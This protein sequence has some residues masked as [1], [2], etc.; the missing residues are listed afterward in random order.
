MILTGILRPGSDGDR[1]W[2]GVVEFDDEFGISTSY[3][4][5]VLAERQGG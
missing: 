3:E 2:C 1:A 5:L 4:P